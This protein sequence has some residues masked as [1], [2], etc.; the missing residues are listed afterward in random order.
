MATIIGD[1]QFAA[2]F[3]PF[4]GRAWFNTAHQGPLP[5]VAVQAA[6]ECLSQRIRP[7]EIQDA[8]FFDVPQRLRDALARLIGASSADIVLGNST[9][10]GLDLLANG[11]RWE[12][13]DEI[14]LVKGDFPANIYPWFIL[15]E[16]GV[17]IRFCEIQAPGIRAEDLEKELSRK[18]RLFCTS[19]VNSFTG[20][21]T[22]IASLGRLCRDR[23]VLF[24][25]NASQALGARVLDVRD[26]AV[27]A[28]TCCGYKWMCGPYGT[29]FC[30][31]T[32]ALRE[33]LVPQH[34]YW[35]PMQAGK[36]L[37]QMRD[38]ALRQD[39]G[40][41]AWDIFC[42]ANFFN[43]VPWIA[44]LHYIL[45][46]G[47]ERIAAY[48]QQIVEKLVRGL[49]RERFELLSPESGVSRSTLIVIRPLNLHDGLQW[50]QRLARAG[51]D[52]AVREGNL[53]IAPHL[54]NTMADVDRLLNELSS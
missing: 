38:C 19:W 14:L 47:P 30:W 5:R 10:Y 2:D 35:L 26:T 15:R 53:R 11:I 28:V 22:D 1:G 36:P 52:V 31:L 27:D 25:L 21:A 46:A 48:D 12:N 3:G 24:V 4:N 33:S 29:G 16:R 41:K 9:S 32:P 54:H 18:T 20:H 13:G 42:T 8:D 39:L 51:V 45:E 50:Q 37:D 7:S 44:C 49:D 40:A 43:F 17:Q 6:Q 34:A 23:G